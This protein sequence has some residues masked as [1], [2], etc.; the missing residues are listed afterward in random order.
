[1]DPAPADQK[2]IITFNEYAYANN[3]PI[4][5]IDQDGRSTTLAVLLYGGATITLPVWFLWASAAAI[6]GYC[7]YTIYRNWVK[8]YLEARKTKNKS[9]KP[10]GWKPGWPRDNKGGFY[11][12]RTGSHW[13]WHQHC[14][15]L[16]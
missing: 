14:P 15:E 8:P 13:H 7:G 16:L 9:P 1:M 10:P 11:D 3:N 12:P 5:N 2:D 4:K 6:I